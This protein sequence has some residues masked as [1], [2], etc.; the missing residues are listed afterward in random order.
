MPLTTHNFFLLRTTLST[1]YFFIFF[2]N[3]FIYLFIFGCIVSSLLCTGLLQL[4]QAGATLCCDA[5]ASH[6]S[7]FSCCGA[8][9]LGA[10]PS[11]VVA[12]GLRSCGTRAQLLHGTWDLPGS[13]LKP[14]P[15]ALAGRFLTTAPPGKSPQYFLET[16]ID[17]RK[18]TQ[19]LINKSTLMITVSQK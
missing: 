16:H 7:G 15:P 9:A 2:K 4:Q 14:M 1:F 3:L 17:W 13:W 6:C 11:V 12:C 19:E 10:Q 18:V 8:W 5:W